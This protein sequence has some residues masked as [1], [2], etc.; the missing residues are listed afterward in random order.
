RDG[1]DFVRH[2]NG[3]FAIALWDGERQRLVLARDR[4]GIRP[5]FHTRSGGRFWFAAVVKALQATAPYTRTLDPQGLSQ[6]LS[7]WATADPHTTWAGVQSLP[8]GC[9]LSIERDGRQ[10]LT[11]YWDWNFPPAMDSTPSRFPQSID[12]AVAELRELLIDAV[13][14][15]LRADV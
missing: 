4:A 10:A 15:Q 8:P 9:L 6:A 11:R 5:L 7:W 14:L 2:L 12:A 1:D 13:R 3:Q